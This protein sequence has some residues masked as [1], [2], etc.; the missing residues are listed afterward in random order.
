MRA[1]RL[2]ALVLL[3]QARRR[4]TA[5]DLAARLEVSVRTIYRDLDALSAAGVPVYAARG[6]GGGVSLPDGYRL[7]LTALHRDEASALFLS[8]VPGP[9]TDLGAGQV[10]EAALRKL[11]AALPAGA[12]H[13]AERARQR[14]HLDP[15]EWWQ[16]HEPVP[17]L[18]L[19]QEGVWQE[20]RLRLTYRRRDGS[21][22]TRV[23]EPYGL[24][25]KAGVWYLV[26][27]DAA[28]IPHGPHEADTLPD[29]PGSMA[30]T[31]APAGGAATPRGG[32]QA[33]PHRVAP[34]RVFRVSRVEAVQLTE[35]PAHRPAAFDLPAFWAAWCASFERDRPSYPVRL[36]IAADFVPALPRIFGEGIRAV[37]DGQGSVD[38][39]GTLVLPLTFENVEVACARVLGLGPQVE[40]LSPPELRQL[41]AQ[42]ASAV[43]TVY[44]QPS[45]SATPPGRPHTGRRIAPQRA[46]QAP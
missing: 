39:D 34:P 42:R 33:P 2:I 13:E 7:D 5:P 21:T 44:Q 26:A 18:R 1:D 23:V 38:A 16:T 45:P 31:V 20:R 11:S 46:E 41:V 4:I 8:A 27:A 32:P 10:L 35:E 22:A 19:V 6:T 24:V 40:V 28:P 17:H 30:G 29:N 43:A 9:L 25:A 14:L 15:A 36:R 3:L 37:I 12:R